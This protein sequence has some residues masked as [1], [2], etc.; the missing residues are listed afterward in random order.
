MHESDLL[1]KEEIF[2][3]TGKTKQS[4]QRR[5][6]E[7]LGIKATPRPGRNA[8]LIVFRA[9]RDFALGLRRTARTTEPPPLTIEPNFAAL[10]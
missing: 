7:Q 2:E 10:D 1:T 3:L 4:A 9:H 5:A 8:G 6:L